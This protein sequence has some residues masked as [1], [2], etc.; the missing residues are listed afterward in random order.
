MNQEEI[1]KKVDHTILSVGATF[2][3]VKNLIDDAIFY[4][5]ASVCISPCYVKQAKEYAEQEGLTDLS[6]I[7][8]YYINNAKEYVKRLREIRNMTS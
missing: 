6:T 1:L 7:A 3:D 2:D 5:T 4:D 8:D